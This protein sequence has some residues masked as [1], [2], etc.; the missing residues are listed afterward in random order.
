MKALGA[1]A[2]VLC[3]FFWSGAAGAAPVASAATAGAPVAA[4]PAA[5]VVV[6][7]WAEQP[8]DQRRALPNDSRP[9]KRREPLHMLPPLPTDPAAVGMVRRV[10]LPDG[11][12]VAALT[13]DLCELDTVTTG[14]NAAIINFLRAEKLPATLFMGGKWMRTHAARVRQVLTE[15]LFE[16]GNHAW[17]HGNFALLSPEGMRAQVLWTQ[18]QYELLREDALAAARAVGGPQPSIPPVPVL[19]RLPYGRCSPQALDLLAG[20]GLTVVQWDVVAEGGG[21]NSAPKQALEVAR[22]VRPGSILLFHANRVPHGSAAL[23]RGVVAALRAQ[24]YSFVTVSRL[25]RM[26]EPRRTTDGYFTVPGD[27]HALD[28]RFGVDGTGRHTP[29]TGR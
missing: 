5:P 17:S 23:L 27:N 13:F 1:V 18:A 16:V 21:D 19:F 11:P 20:L 29:F 4:S 6:D 12:K 3:T 7:P 8:W 2:A 22:R 28:G 26:G 15:P 10:A 9:P 14:Y 25:L 24:G